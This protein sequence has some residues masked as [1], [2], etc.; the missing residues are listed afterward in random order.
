MISSTNPISIKE[1]LDFIGFILS[2]VGALYFFFIYS[3][4]TES[5]V[6]NNTF[7]KYVAHTLSVRKY[8][9]KNKEN[10]EKSEYIHT[11]SNSRDYDKTDWS[12]RK[13]IAFWSIDKG[14]TLSFGSVAIG[15]IF[16][17]LSKFL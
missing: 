13:K 4:I 11:L 12:I 17:L 15:F 3:C 10:K 2:G 1:F 7:N 9:L 5:T 8:W 6:V 14:S 16:Q